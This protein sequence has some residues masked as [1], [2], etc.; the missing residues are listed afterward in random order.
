MVV[1]LV[2]LIGIMSLCIYGLSFEF[3]KFI[4]M[5]FDKKP[6]PTKVLDIVCNRTGKPL[7]SEEVF[8]GMCGSC[9]RQNNLKAPR[10]KDGKYIGNS[11]Y[12]NGG[13]KKDSYVQS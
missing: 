11:F 6:K 4:D 8:F 5:W 13:V 10:E 2:A 12:C 3:S 7:T 9:Y 1:A